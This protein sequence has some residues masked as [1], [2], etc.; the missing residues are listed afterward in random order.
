MIVIPWSTEPNFEQNIT[1]DN[2]VYVMNACWNA[3]ANTWFLS[4]STL[5]GVSIITKKKVNLLTNLIAYSYAEEKPEGALIVMSMDLD[6]NTP[7]TRDNF[8]KEVQ[9]LYLSPDEIL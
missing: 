8:D 9:L 3:R 4:L 5:D 1:L 7:I 6:I 2:K